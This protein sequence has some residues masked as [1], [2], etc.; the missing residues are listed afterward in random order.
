MRVIA[1]ILFLLFIST[2]CFAGPTTP[3]GITAQII[4]D[5]SRRDL[6][7]LS[8]SGLTDA[9]LPDSDL[10]QWIDE[11]VD[12]IVNK[13]RC[14]ES[15]ASNI[16]VYNLQRRYLINKNFLDVEVV[17]FDTGN[18]TD[19]RKPMVYALDRVE[20]RDIGHNWETGN[21][22]VYCVWNNYL[23]IWPIP[24][25]SGTTIYLYTIDQASGVTAVTSAIETPAYLDQALPYYVKAKGL[26]KFGHNGDS[27]LALF[28]AFVNQYIVNVLRRKPV[29]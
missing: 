1:A 14:L 11:A 28:D 26:Y 10:I 25:S 4:V 29:E 21:P 27:F 6:N 7:A 15:G 23:E 9:A 2:P 18:T 13:T 20:K 24:S 19:P 3:S 12:I 8:H 16:A 22:K 5:R 17:E